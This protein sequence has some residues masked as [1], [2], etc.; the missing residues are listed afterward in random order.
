MAHLLVVGDTLT[1]LL[2][3]AEKLQTLHSDIEV[4]LAHVVAVDPAHDLWPHLRGIR[5]P[6][7]GIPR[8]L[9]LGTLR[10]KNGRDFCIAYHGKP[11]VIVRLRDEKY[12]RLLIATES[13]DAAVALAA[14]V[15]QAKA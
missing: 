10:F 6:G 9:L 4:P 1:L 3:R 5:A 14:E 8:V 13:F 15:D 12:E 2:S 7:T 11:G